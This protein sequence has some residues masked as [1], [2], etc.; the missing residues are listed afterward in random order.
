MMD[1]VPPTQDADDDPDAALDDTT[2][3][4]MM[5]PSN[6]KQRAGPV[7]GRWKPMMEIADA[8]SQAG[9]KDTMEVMKKRTGRPGSS[10]A[11]PPPPHRN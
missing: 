5:E 6:Y 4:T 7:G 10:A 8:V 2:T 1:P 3:T 11:P 9:P